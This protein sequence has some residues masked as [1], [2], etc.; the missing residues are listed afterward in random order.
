M[1]SFNSPAY[2]AQVR[3]DV[4][5]KRGRPPGAPASARG[6]RLSDGLWQRVQHR[7]ARARVSVSGMV[8]ALLRDALAMD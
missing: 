4:A 3:Q 5:A 6:V 8:E 7:A 1:L 2:L